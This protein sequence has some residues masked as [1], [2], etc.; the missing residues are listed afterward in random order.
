MSHKRPLASSVRTDRTC[1]TN[2]ALSGVL[3]G[4][5]HWKRIHTSSNVPKKNY[6]QPS[7]NQITQ[8]AKMLQK[9]LRGETTLA[10]AGLSSSS[11][12]MQE[13]TELTAV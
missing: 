6:C 4:Q 8:N 3:A 1:R 7:F 9:P 13:E 10:P 11:D 12:V 2:K 5:H